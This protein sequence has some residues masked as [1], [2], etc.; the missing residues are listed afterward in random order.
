[1]TIPTSK[2]PPP[3][4]PLL[5]GDNHQTATAWLLFF[6]GLADQIV[7]VAASVNTEMSAE[8]EARIA[9]DAQILSRLWFGRS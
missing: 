8:T 6:L 4:T 1:M 7:G 9:E 5:A 2:R 3:V